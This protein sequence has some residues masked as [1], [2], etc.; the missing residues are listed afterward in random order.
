MKDKALIF[1]FGAL[2]ALATA[3]WMR[4]PGATSLNALPV[5]SFQADAMLTPAPMAEPVSAQTVGYPVRQ[6]VYRESSA[7]VRRAAAPSSG[8]YRLEESGDL[9][10]ARG[11]N[12]AYRAP[13]TKQRSKMA[14]AAIIGGGAAAGAA[15]G[16]LA[17]GGKGAAIGAL[18]GGAAGV[19]Y[20]RM[21]HKKTES[22]DD[23]RS[24]ATYRDSARNASYDPDTS[25]YP[26]SGQR[27]TMD[28]IKIIGGSAAA[29]AAIGG[30]AGGGK[31]AAIGALSAG[32]AG[33]VYDHMTKN[34]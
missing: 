26:R 8:R 7:P 5:S 32:A 15:I 9:R 24:T 22:V 31:G 14:S 12:V 20:D 4:T 28:R 18:S 33:A 2:T 29:G 21:T 13:V 16:G 30:M 19:V 34:R 6:S 27:S 1:G 25:E 3:G 10:S 23:D 17:G 11:R